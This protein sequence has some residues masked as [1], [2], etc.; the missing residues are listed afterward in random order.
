M[1]KIYIL[2]AGVAMFLGV[3]GCSD[4]LDKPKPTDVLTA[5]DIYSNPE[6][7]QAY[8]A[9]IYRLF[10]AQYIRTDMGGVYSMYM[11]RS[12]K[13]NDLIQN[14]WYNFD[15][16]HE[17]REPNYTRVVG[18]W[19]FCYEGVKHAN[20]LIKEIAAS[21]ALSDNAKVVLDAEA[22]GL[23]AFFNFQLYLEYY[24]RNSGL[25][26]PPLYTE[27]AALEPKG[28]SNPADF[29]AQLI[30]DINDAVAGL[31]SDRINKSYMNKS[32]ANGL[33]AR[34]LM[35][36]DKDWGQ[37]EI[38]ANAAYGG[39]LAAALDASIYAGGFDDLT[40]S[41]VMWS[42]DQQADQS[43]YYYIAPHAFTDHT[44]DAYFG[45]FFNNTFVATFSATDVRNEFWEGYPVGDDDYRNF[46]SNKFEFSF[47][48]DMHIM[49][50]AEMVLIDA[51]A[52]YRN[53][54]EDTAHD[55]LFA[56]QSNRDP[57]AVKSANTGAD[58]LEE[59]LLER[60]KELYAEIG[61][62]WFDAKRL[63][64]G[65]T[66]DGNHRVMVAL[67]PND[68]RFFLKIPQDEIDANDLIDDTINDNR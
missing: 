16:A 9:G 24:S 3:A 30:S 40:A 64:R 5:N 65:I 35:A 4:Y 15:Y 38:A 37:V 58:L 23:R 33:K 6:G 2:I 61:V 53:G 47:E 44:E 66:R 67:E 54:D 12:V 50:T 20:T 49:R 32:V 34:I 8:F 28:M 48:A 68:K 42:M 13:G 18:D 10:R 29:E 11:S 57:N 22:K 21:D 43:N 62:E 1:K 19:Q 60:R 56:L 52:N 25:Q 55:L 17:N 45:T 27:P 7:V 39:N 31:T 41:E 59:I 63:G 46:I 14:S 36:L 26:T 51:E